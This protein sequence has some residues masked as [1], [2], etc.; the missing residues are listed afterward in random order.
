MISIYY[1]FNKNKILLNIKLLHHRIK[2]KKRL[3]INI[4]QFGLVHFLL[5]KP[6]VGSDGTHIQNT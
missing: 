6:A 1:T 4:S 3:Y 2:K 5:T